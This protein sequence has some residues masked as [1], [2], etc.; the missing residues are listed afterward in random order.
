MKFIQIKE[1]IIVRKKDIVSIERLEDGGSR[2][3]TINASYDCPFFYESILQLLE[4]E[5][6]E[7]KTQDSNRNLWQGQYFAG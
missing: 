2:V 6:I 5:D 7:E 4:T 1:G 3:S